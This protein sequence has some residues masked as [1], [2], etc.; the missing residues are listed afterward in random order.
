MYDL[1]I[2]KKLCT[3]STMSIV[4]ILTTMVLPLYRVPFLSFILKLVILSL[5]SYASY[6]NILQTNKL[7]NANSE[8][9]DVVRQLNANVICGY[10]FTL[11]LGLLALFVAKGMI[12]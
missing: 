5:L 12:A 2:T 6:L 11:F 7:R 3:V 10:V 9:M 8:S 4:L 1:S